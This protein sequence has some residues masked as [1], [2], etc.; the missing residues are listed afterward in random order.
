MDSQDIIKISRKAK[1]ET[2]VFI[3]R[4]LND[5]AKGWPKI[6]P[7]RSSHTGSNQPQQLR[8]SDKMTLISF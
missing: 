8:V 6:Y 4:Y 5:H 1:N 2:E 3:N 7:C